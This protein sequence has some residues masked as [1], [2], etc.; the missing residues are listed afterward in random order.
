MLTSIHDFQ[1]GTP[2]IIPTVEELEQMLLFLGLY[3]T[4]GVLHVQ[5]VVGEEMEALQIE[6]PAARATILNTLIDV[7]GNA[8]EAARKQE[9]Q[10]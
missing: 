6:N 8:L 3:S 2:G 5:L 1:P 4:T 10:A 7:V 9:G